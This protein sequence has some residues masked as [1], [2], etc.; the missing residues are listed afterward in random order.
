M[1]DQNGQLHIDLK[2]HGFDAGSGVVTALKIVAQM[3]V[4]T[5]LS[6]LE[7]TYGEQIWE[8]TFGEGF[9]RDG[10]QDKCPHI[11]A[12]LAFIEW[13]KHLDKINEK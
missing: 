9:R 2:K 3:P 13:K 12:A 1:N 5:S 11:A 4:G 10:R 7:T 8:C 6:T